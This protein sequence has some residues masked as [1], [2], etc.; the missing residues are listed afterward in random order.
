VYY[1]GLRVLAVMVTGM[2]AAAAAEAAVQIVFKCRGFKYRDFVF[3]FFTR[4]EIT[5]MDGS[6]V[7]TGLLLAFTLPPTVPLWMPAVGA[8]FGVL[9]AKQL[10]GG[11]GYNIFN[12]ALAGRAFLLAAWPG[13]MTAWQNPV[14]WGS[15]SAVDAVSSATPL[16]ALALGNQTTP[17]LNLVL[18]ATGGSLGE[19]SALALLLGAAYMFYKRTISWH[20]PVGFFGTM[21]AMC[22]MHGHDPLFHLF[23][24]SAILGAFF[25][26]TDPVTTPVSPAGRFVFGCGA[27]LITMLIR[28]H[29]A[30]PEGV[31]YAILIMNC[32][33]PLIDKC[34]SRRFKPDRIDVPLADT[35]L[36][37]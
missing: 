6:A 27:G 9:V 30:Y 1:F 32:F 24:G 29:G 14:V 2:L 5:V 23:A 7:L 33:C 17:L 12:P 3:S 35:L 37:K 31:C 28:L 16:D 20:A 8:V 4:E 21:V 34:T 36:K 19:T 13:P 22:L 11:L 10:F 26:V 15:G 18:G 25:M